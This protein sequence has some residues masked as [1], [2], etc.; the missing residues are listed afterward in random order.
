MANQRHDHPG[1]FLREPLEGM[2]VQK[3][4]QTLA[5]S[6]QVEKSD[7]KRRFGDPE[8]KR[9]VDSS[10]VGS[11]EKNITDSDDDGEFEPN[12]GPKK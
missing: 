2:A 9:A 7:E 12:W 3:P 4:P 6:M 10:D 11:N 8:H 1:V 5:A